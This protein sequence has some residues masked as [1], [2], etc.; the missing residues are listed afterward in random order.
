MCWAT[1][2]ENRDWGDRRHYR[3][4]DELQCAHDRRLPV[5][6]VRNGEFDDTR[7][8]LALTADCRIL[9]GATAVR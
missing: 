5:V 1:P 7:N 2:D 4:A 9:V 3:Q 6:T 8:G